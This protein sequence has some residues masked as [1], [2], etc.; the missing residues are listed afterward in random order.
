MCT[1]ERA[2]LREEA[3]ELRARG[4]RRR[5][6]AYVW[7][8]R[9][10]EPQRSARGEVL[11]PGSGERSTIKARV[12][13]LWRVARDDAEVRGKGSGAT[14]REDRT[15]QDGRQCGRELRWVRCGRGR[16]GRG[17]REKTVRPTVWHGGNGGGR[18]GL[19]LAV[20]DRP[21]SRVVQYQVH[22]PRSAR[23]G[24]DSSLR[25]KYLLQRTRFFTHY[26]PAFTVATRY[27]SALRYACVTLRDATLRTRNG[28]APAGQLPWCAGGQT[29]VPA[30]RA[31][32]CRCAV[33]DGGECLYI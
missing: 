25:V 27:G 28:D 12:E 31:A 11:G 4:G 5:R 29:V 18:P 24:S 16:G 33:W 1:V 26:L 6:R 21:W 13:V 23:V 32:L 15:G 8:R 2:G 17:R 30:C 9:R 10:C 22:G 20:F 19:G 7:V 3:L 14:R